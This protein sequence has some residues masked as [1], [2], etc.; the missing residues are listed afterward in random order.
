MVAIPKPTFHEERAALAAGFSIVAGVDEAGMGCWAGPVVAAA[1]ILPFDS[2]LALIRDSKTLSSL[3]RDRL[4]KDIKAVAAAWAVGVASA[5][6]IDEHNIRGANAL[7]MR[8]AVE[9]L[10]LLPQLVLSDAFAIP[11]L[12]MPVRSVMGGDRKVKSIAAASVIAKTFRDRLMAELD[13]RHP[14]YGFSRH[15]GYGTA[16]HR[17]ALHALGPCPEHRRTYAPVRE[18]IERT[19]AA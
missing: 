3:Q 6:E 10:A 17:R 5:E 9:G 13:C 14:G 12:A 11:G 4:E 7:A 18:V 19:T 1:V 16:E 2:R 8:R 15:M